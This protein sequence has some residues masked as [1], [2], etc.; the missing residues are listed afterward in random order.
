MSFFGPMQQAGH[1]ETSAPKS[2]QI[3]L[4][5]ARNI[6]FIN[7]TIHDHDTVTTQPPHD[8]FECVRT[9]GGSN[10][11][12]RGNKFWGCEIYALST[13][14]WGGVNYIENNWFGGADWHDASPSGM[15]ITA[16]PTIPGQIYI[17]FNSFSSRD[18]IT[19]D[20]GENH[21]VSTSS[22]ISSVRRLLLERSVSRTLST[23]TTSMW[24]GS[25][26]APQ[27]RQHA[28]AVR[29]RRPWPEDELPPGAREMACRQ[30][31]ARLA[32]GLAPGHRLRREGPQHTEGRR[33]GRT[34][35]GQDGCG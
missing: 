17:R 4:I 14:D 27:R 22:A 3:E 5:E 8:H 15:A 28:V 20:A 34:L 2:G 10:Y 1:C 21:A 26:E 11:V 31:R 16:D 12:F 35:G 25:V 13:T 29:Q 23:N 19:S 18:A 30:L 9:S 7:N 6:K 33:L 24:P 32:A